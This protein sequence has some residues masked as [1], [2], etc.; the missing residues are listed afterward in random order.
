MRRC[1][2]D[3]DPPAGVL[4]TVSTYRRPPLRGTVSKKSQASRRIGLGAKEPGPG[5]DG[6]L[7]RRVDPCSLQISHT[8]EAA[9][10]IPKTSNSPWMRR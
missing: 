3:P 5:G 8:V 7:R 1:T 4:E 2:Q 10:L 9:I 6:A